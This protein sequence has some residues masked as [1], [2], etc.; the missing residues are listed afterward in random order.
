MVSR[1][2]LLGLGVTASAIDHW[3]ARGRL[4]PR[5]RGV[6]AVGH[7]VISPKGRL[8]GALL[9]CGSGAVISHRDAAAL[10]NVRRSSRVPVD[11]TVA[12]R[13]RVGQKGIDIH[14]VRRLDP[15]DLTEIDGISVTTLARAFLDLAEVLPERQV[16]RA[17]EEAERQN[18][19][20]L[21]AIHQTLDRNPGRHG[22]KPLLHILGDAVIE[23]MSRSDLEIAFLELCR[24]HGIPR[25]LVNRPI[26]Q[27][28]ADMVWPQHRL[29]VELDSRAYHL[30]RAAFEND[31]M[32]DAAFQLA[33]FRVVRI[34]DWQLLRHPE[35]VAAT[36]LALLEQTSKAA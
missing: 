20:D 13:T 27:Y 28:E 7:S 21:G 12:G 29:I 31:R 35:R 15:L 6:Y 36:I 17:I 9:A 4:H 8:W 16:A 11:I 19:V 18:L 30:N 33:G 25:P 24:D 3:V 26:G 2:Q 32:K 5:Y 22:H 1:G 10:W 34:T 14:L 23:P